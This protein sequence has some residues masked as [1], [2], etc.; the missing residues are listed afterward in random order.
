MLAQPGVVA[1]AEDDDEAPDAAVL[2]AADA[3]LAQLAAM[4]DTE[5]AALAR[6]LTARLAELDALRDQIGKLARACRG[7]AQAAAE[8]LNKLLGD[9][10]AD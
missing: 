5:G 10:A 8:R 9:E 6:E 4:R 3:A 1:L 7:R 2:A